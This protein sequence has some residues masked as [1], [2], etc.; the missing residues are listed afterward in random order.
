M[1]M[2]KPVFFL[3]CLTGI[4]VAAIAEV[5]VSDITG[6]GT[7]ATCK[8]G[9]FRTKPYKVKIIPKELEGLTVISVPRG[10]HNKPGNGFSFKVEAPVTVYLFV[11]KRYKNPNLEGWK[12]INMTALW[13]AGNATL[14]DIIYQKDFPAGVIKIPGNPKNIIPHMAVI[15]EK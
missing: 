11:D 15:K 2:L 9:I 6:E 5:K 1:K 7:K 13:I 14:Q 3:L 12:L 8:A 10:D 4:C